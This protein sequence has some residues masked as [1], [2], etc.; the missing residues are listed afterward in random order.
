LW[1]AYWR[2]PRTRKISA[3]RAAP[4]ADPELARLRADVL[5]KM[6]E[7]HAEAQKLLAFHEVEKGVYDE[8]LQRRELIKV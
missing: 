8:Y 5:E 1:D 4:A 6:K 2:V 3:Q 7:S